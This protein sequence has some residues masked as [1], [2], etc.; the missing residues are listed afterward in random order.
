MNDK[1]ISEAGNYLKEVGSQGFETY[2]HGLWITSVIWLIVG[3][4]LLLIGTAL[5]PKAIKNYKTDKESPYDDLS[6]TALIVALIT[7]LYVFGG[8]A[9]MINLNGVV[10]PEYTAIQNLITSIKGEG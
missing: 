6:G 10:A 7:I 4:C 9:V 1:L 3:I 5:I 2:V 8:V